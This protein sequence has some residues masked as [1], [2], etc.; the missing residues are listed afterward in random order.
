MPYI[1]PDGNYYDA[2]DKVASGSIECAVRPEGKVL[3]DNWQT[4]PL[5]PAVCWRDKTQTEIDAEEQETEDNMSFDNVLIT[6]AK[7]LH[8]HENRIRALEGK[9]PITLRQLIKGLRKL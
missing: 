6:V 9:Q 7:G 8:N 4:D 1:T 2:S 5:N 3:G